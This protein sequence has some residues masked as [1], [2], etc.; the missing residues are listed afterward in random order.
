MCSY[1]ELKE[2]FAVTKAETWREKKFNILHRL[3]A[4]ICLPETLEY[5]V[6]LPKSRKRD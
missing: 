4:Y 5:N 1:I 2:R 6:I 3:G